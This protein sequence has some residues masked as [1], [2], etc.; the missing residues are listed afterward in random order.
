MSWFDILKIISPR[1]FLEELSE[2][3]GGKVKGYSSKRKDEFTLSLP[4]GYIK[5]ER[6]GKGEFYVTVRLQDRKLYEK[7]NSH[8]L[9]SLQSEVEDM[10]SGEMEK[11]AGTFTTTSHPNLFRPTFGGG[12]NAKDDEED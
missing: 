8:N 5:V 7:L 11:V 9:K 4:T 2:K 3:T 6:E 12:K 1:Q 10:V